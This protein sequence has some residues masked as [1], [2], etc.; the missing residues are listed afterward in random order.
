[1]KWAWARWVLVV[2]NGLAALAFGV[3]AMMALSAGSDHHI[4][5]TSLLFTLIP[6]GATGATFATLAYRQAQRQGRVL[7]TIIAALSLLFAM[8]TLPFVF[9]TYGVFAI[10]AS[11][12]LGDFATGDEPQPVTGTPDHVARVLWRRGQSDAA[13]R[14]ELAARKVPADEIEKLLYELAVEEE[15]RQRMSP[16]R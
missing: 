15:V 7:Q 3:F 8:A 14:A 6:L 13:I 11:W 10:V 16:G 12:W 2:C 5:G 9:V 4:G 1:M